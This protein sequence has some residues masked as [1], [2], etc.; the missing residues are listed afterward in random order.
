MTIFAIDTNLLVYAHNTA[1]T[2]HRQAAAFL[3]RVM[4][5]RDEAG[6]LSVCIPAQVLMEF[7][8]VVTWQRLENPLSLSEALLVVEDYVDTGITII[9]QRQ[10]QLRTFLDL[11]SATTTRKKVFDVALAATLQDNGVSG[12]YTANIAD[13]QEFDFLEVTN[14]LESK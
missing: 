9:Y 1:S 14:P 10:T 13:F 2:F 8:H 5:D 11:L 4:N 6:N 12:L 7:V 3:E